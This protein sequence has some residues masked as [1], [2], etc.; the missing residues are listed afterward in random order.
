MKTRYYFFYGEHCGA[1]KEVKPLIDKFSL[2][3]DVCPL[4][5]NEQNREAYELF[6]IEYLPTL[7]LISE[8]FPTGKK[9]E[10]KKQ[11]TNYLTNKI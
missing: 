7:I 5:D 9:F 8:D 10:G 6:N 4:E 2:S 3:N 1:C 11:V